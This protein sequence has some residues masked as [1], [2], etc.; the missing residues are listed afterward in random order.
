[1]EEP[2]EKSL[3]LLEEKLGYRFNSKSLLLTAITHR[4]FSP[5][6]RVNEQQRLEF[7]GDAILNFCVSSAIYEKFPEWDEGKMSLCRG[8]IVRNEYLGKVA[9]RL[10]IGEH[11]I[12]GKGEEVDGG[13]EKTSILGDTLE[14]IIGAI[15]LDGGYEAVKSFIKKH[16]LKYALRRVKSAP[17]P[18]SAL[19]ELALK[20]Y[21]SLPKYSLVKEEG[22]PHAKKFRVCVEVFGK[23]A[24]G[25]GRSKKEAEKKAAMNML[26]KEE[27]N[28]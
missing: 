14:A 18:K 26:K 4:S 13:R 24:Y 21:R 23:R 22:P 17:D 20:K 9:K 27:K 10:A 1:M 11:I 3:E 2:K 15:Y 28:G 12:L 19:Q 25:S 16:I 5:S 6:T 7:L 8:S